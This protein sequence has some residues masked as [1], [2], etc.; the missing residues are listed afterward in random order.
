MIEIGRLCVKIAGRDAGRKCVVIDVLDGNRVLVDG[1]TRRR[2]CNILHLEPLG[3]MLQISKN[4][5][6]NEVA[7]AFKQL[8]LEARSTKAKKPA[9]RSRRIRKSRSPE[10]K[11]AQRKAKEEKKKV[12]KKKPAEELKVEKSV[13]KEGLSGKIEALKSKEKPAKAKSVKKDSAKEAKAE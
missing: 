1:E 11:E 2:P 10:E 4:A 7:E 9:P 8:N 6:H 13:N 5:S 12:A 3:E